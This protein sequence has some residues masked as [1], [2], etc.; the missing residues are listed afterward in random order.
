MVVNAVAPAHVE[1]G[2]GVAKGCGGRRVRDSAQ[3]ADM[4]ARRRTRIRIESAIALLAAFL[5][6]LTMVWKD[7]IEVV[8]RVDPDGH[9]GAAETGVV[10]GLL[11]LALLLGS[12]A[13]VERL[14]ARAA[15]AQ[16]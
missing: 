2:V 9:G 1:R 13:G 14:G 6:L 4:T 8:F 16:S 10:L 5:G 3:G 7:W 12:L 15:A 11:A